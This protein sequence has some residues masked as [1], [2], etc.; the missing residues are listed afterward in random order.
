MYKGFSRLEPKI[1][2]YAWLIEFEGLFEDGAEIQGFT[3]VCG[4]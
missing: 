1:N 2:R 4:S 3:R